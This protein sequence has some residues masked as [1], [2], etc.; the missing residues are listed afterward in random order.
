MVQFPLRQLKL[1]TRYS[2]NFSN[3]IGKYVSAIKSNLTLNSSF[4]LQDF[5]QIINGNL[6]DIANQ[7]LVFGKIDT[8]LTDWLNLEYAGSWTF[9]NN[10]LEEQNNRNNMF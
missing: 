8:D 4:A 6:V 1:N 2:H 10:K 3:R 9:S 5:Q 7:N